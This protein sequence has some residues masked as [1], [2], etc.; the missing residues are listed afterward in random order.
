MEFFN[1][2]HCKYTGVKGF[3][4]VYNDAIRYR[5]MIT[6]K[7]KEKTRTLI[8]WE[9]YGLEA[10]LDAFPDKKRS[11]Y[12]SWKDQWIKGGKKIEALNEKSRE[13]QTK[14]KRLW[15]DEVKNEIKRLRS[16]EVHPNLGEKKL[17]PLLLKFCGSNNFKCPKPITIGRII[18]DCGGLRTFPQKV[19]HFG[20]IKKVNR[21]KV[22][23]K[24]KDFKP[25]YPGHLVAL[26]TVERFVNGCRRYVITFE[27]IYTR[28]SFAWATKSHA[29]S[30]AKEF[31]DLCVKVFPFSYQF[32]YVLTDNGSEFKKHF[33]AELRRLRMVHF[34][35]YPKTPK[36]NAHLERFN[37]TIQD[38]FIDYHS[39]LLLTPDKFNNR[40]IDYLIFYNT[41]R[42]H[43]AFQNKLSPIQFMMS[44]NKI[45][46]TVKMPS[47]SRIGCG[48]TCL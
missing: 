12:Y 43:C 28:F 38:E 16:R 3:L 15:P 19:S 32:L 37:R 10:T 25:L 31:F 26:D 47:E 17:Y 8:F 48:Y 30:A 24:P 40:L 34:H 6:A 5:Y 29:S 23:R 9:K 22:L 7:A 36:M 39:F 46:I 13:P 18:K 44:L 2:I 11:T 21:Q 45:P 1:H 35:T 41:E 14:R 20:K 33:D 27:D 42:V 4:T